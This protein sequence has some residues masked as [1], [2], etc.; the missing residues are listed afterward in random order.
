MAG[1]NF[2][3]DV[4]LSFA[5][6][7]RAFVDCVAEILKN[8][9]LKVFYDKYEQINLW[10]KNLYT[11]LDS[12]YT[13]KAR[14]CVMF[15]SSY[16]AKKLW[17]NHER[18]SAQTRAFDNSEEY[19]LPFRMDDTLI[20]GIRQTVGYLSIKDYNCDKLA[21]AIIEKV[22]F[23]E[24]YIDNIRDKSKKD[25]EPKVISD[26]GVLKLPEGQ[27]EIKIRK[28]EF[29]SNRLSRAF[30]GVRGLKWFAEPKE[31]IERLKMLLAQ[32]LSFK[33]YPD[34]DINAGGAVTPIWWF[35]GGASM[36]IK[37]FEVLSE[38]MCRI[39]SDELE[40]DKLAVYRTARPYKDFI[41][42]KVKATLPLVDSDETRLSVA[43]QLTYKKY[44]SENY[45][46]YKGQIISEEEREDG[47]MF[48]GGKFIDFEETPVSRRRFL[49]SYNIII[50]AQS[51]TY[52][53]TQAD[54][55]FGDKL[56]RWLSE[57]EN[58]EEIIP[59]LEDM[60]N[61]AHLRIDFF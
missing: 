46:L 12:I 8:N 11:H 61:D 39:G 60:E 17:T 41:Y 28:Y 4:T 15:I 29:F 23:S 2:D 37:G 50:C 3:Y 55:F 7:D 6:E 13:N 57:D 43:N 22:K 33:V 40:V 16:Y 42:L 9:G 34:K 54:I 45:A 53:S 49:T 47:A 20:P 48:R 18:E 19:I 52:N 25:V 5:G 26:Y 36:P 14:F 27:Y 21:Q 10:G 56:D 24:D 31:I 59:L 44:A 51:S 58:L 38:T 30:P 32:P 35:R 1:V